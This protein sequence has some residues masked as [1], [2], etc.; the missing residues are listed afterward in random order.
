MVV[1]KV[2]GK[3]KTGVTSM[4]KSPARFI[5]SL[6]IGFAV[7][8]IV[9]L[10]TEYVYRKFIDPEGKY[11]TSPVPFYYYFLVEPIGDPAHNLKWDDLFLLILTIVFLFTRKFVFTLGFF[12]GWYVS[13]NQHFYG[14]I[15]ELPSP[16]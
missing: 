16:T 6:G 11:G 7:G 9:D 13:S 10:V 5:V 8:V 12:L 15:E 4:W 3:V 2:V 1:G 14:M